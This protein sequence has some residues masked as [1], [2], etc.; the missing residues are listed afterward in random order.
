MHRISY[1]TVVP[2]MTS[3]ILSAFHY[4]DEKSGVFLSPHVRLCGY[5]AMAHIDSESL[6]LMFAEACIPFLQKR[7]GNETTLGV[8]SCWEVSEHS[9]ILKRIQSDSELIRKRLGTGNL[10]QTRRRK[11]PVA[12]ERNSVSVAVGHIDDRRP[13]ILF[14]DCVGL[15]HS[16]LGCAVLVRGVALDGPALGAAHAVGS[17]L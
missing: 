16:A 8:E 13:Q 11:S 15:I 4:Q 17:G 12:M 14:Q 2:R 5:N 6:A 1:F 7:Y 10:R 9:R 3:R